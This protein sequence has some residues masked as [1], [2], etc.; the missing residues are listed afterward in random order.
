MEAHGLRGS[1]KNLLYHLFI[2]T[3][4]IYLLIDEIQKNFR[5]VILWNINSEV[6]KNNCRKT[7]ATVSSH[8][9]PRHFTS[10]RDM[11]PDSY[12]SKVCLHFPRL[13]PLA[14]HFQIFRVY[15]SLRR[16]EALKLEFYSMFLLFE[17]FTSF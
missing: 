11:S 15:V 2:S 8:F 16:R 6:S 13:F 9:W 1:L 14:P 4:N 7:R 10:E 12:F 17:F 3:E 5:L